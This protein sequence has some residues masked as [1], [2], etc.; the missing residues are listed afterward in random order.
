MKKRR[1][2]KILEHEALIK[3]CRQQRLEGLPEEE[4][5]SEMA[6]GEEDDGDDDAESRYDT[7]TTLAHLPNVRFLQE[8][9]GGG[10]TS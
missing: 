5:P 1:N 9:A 2:R 7:V 8:P 4:S 3:R 6:S 10:S